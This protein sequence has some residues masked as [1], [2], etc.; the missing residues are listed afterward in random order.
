[1]QRHSSKSS[2][3]AAVESPPL[4]PLA[5][6]A[7]P[8]YVF[9]SHEHLARHVAGLIAARDSRAGRLGPE[10]RAGPADRQHAGGRLSRADPPAPR[11]RARFLERR[12][13]QPRRV[14]A[15]S[16]RD[17]LQSY[18]RWMHEH[19]FDHVNIPPE[20][21]HIPDGTD[22]RPS[23]LDE[24]CREYE[25]AIRAGRRHRPATAGHR[26]Q[27][28]H[29]LQRARSAPPTAAPALATLDP[30]TR[31][32]AA[33]DFFGEENVPHAGHHDG[34]GHD[35]RRPQD[36]ADRARR[37]QGRH[38]SRGGRRPELAARAGLLPAR[39]SERRCCSMDAAAA[40]KLTAVATPWL[41]GNVEWTDAL[42][43]RAVLWLSEQDRQGAAQARRRRFSRAQ[44]ASAAAASRPGAERGPPRLSL[45]DGHDR[46]SSG[47]HA[48]R[49]ESSA[50]AR[51][52]TTT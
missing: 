18:H 40:S 4:G 23:E 52:P 19:F 38:H 44:P 45:D 43:K 30:V 39:T 28:A 12:H 9:H 1:M 11:G 15:A 36:R 5:G 14:S 34:P 24:H 32:D 21:I 2:D 35:F 37:A 29:R 7:L 42:I 27:R 6:T 31:R 16:D 33:S 8:S 51:T 22:C 47:R 17:R 26:P 48:S 25:A 50:S 10:G 3:P 49:S 46:V 20:N 13:V 41:L